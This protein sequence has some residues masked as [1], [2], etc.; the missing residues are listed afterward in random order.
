MKVVVFIE[1]GVIQDVISN[2]ELEVRIIDGDLDGCEERDVQ[3]I[4]GEDVYVYSS[5]RTAKVDKSKV[6][7]IFREIQKNE[8][9]F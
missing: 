3:R 8:A 5:H 1:G 7:K 9:D 2:N 4:E 6:E